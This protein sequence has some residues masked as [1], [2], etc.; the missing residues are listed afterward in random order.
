MS[1]LFWV[2]AVNNFTYWSGS[3]SPQTRSGICTRSPRP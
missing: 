2:V 3:F 1:A